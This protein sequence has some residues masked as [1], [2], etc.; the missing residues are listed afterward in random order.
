MKAYI[1]KIEMQDITPLIWRRVI[2]P[3]DATFK[4]FHDVIQHTTN[5]QD[6]HLYQ[7]D[8]SELE[9]MF[10]TNDEEAYLE[11]KHFQKNKKEL[12]KKFEKI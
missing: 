2:M 8:L 7:F 1:I 6:Y 5:F 11:H 3:A 4:R 9:N 10:I 12:E